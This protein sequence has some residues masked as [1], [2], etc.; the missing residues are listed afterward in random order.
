M[1]GDIDMNDPPCVELHDHEYVDHGEE[2]G[3]LRHEVACEDLVA[4]ILEKCLPGL[5]IAWGSSFH[6][7]LSDGTG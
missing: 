6:H 7:V 3:V 5:P 1:R 4:V 2:R